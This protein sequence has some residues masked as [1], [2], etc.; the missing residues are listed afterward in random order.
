M[1]KKTCIVLLSALLSMQGFTQDKVQ[2]SLF[3]GWGAGH[4][5]RQDLTFSPM[6]HRAFSPANLLLEYRRDG[7]FYQNVA[8]RFGMYQSVVGSPFTYY[9]TDIGEELQT[10][11]HSFTFIDIGYTFGKEVFRTS[12]FRVLAEGRFLTRLLPSFYTFGSAGSFGYY[13]SSGIEVGMRAEWQVREGHILGAG[14]LL[15]TGSLIARSPYLSQ[16]DTFHQDIYSHNG[17]LTFL[18]LLRHMEPRS[19]GSSQGIDMEAGYTISFSK[20]WE[21]SFR[22]LFSLELDQ[23]PTS[24]TSLYHVVFLGTTINF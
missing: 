2:Q 16:D 14:M 18:S 23:K 19:W 8:T 3:A 21:G 20:K 10:W 4:L 7:R 17:F 12:H 1:K 11:P 9:R 6:I 22:Y 15:P 24:F 5:A 13:I